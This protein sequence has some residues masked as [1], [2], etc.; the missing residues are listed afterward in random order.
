M[1]LV[2][3]H[4]PCSVFDFN[5]PYC[6]GIELVLIRIIECY[7]QHWLDFIDREMCLVAVFIIGF[8]P[9]CSLPFC[10]LCSSSCKKSTASQ[11]WVR[12]VRTRWKLP[13]GLSSSPLSP[14]AIWSNQE[15]KNEEWSAW[16]QQLLCTIGI[17]VTRM[18]IIN[19]G[20]LH[21]YILQHYVSPVLIEKAQDS[22]QKLFQASYHPN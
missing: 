11:I 17:I 15:R 16:S 19:A 21:L 2:S 10:N 4:E 14:K 3:F 9:L 20:K 12:D 5:N 18:K 7:R 22:I 6:N 8:T 1:N 13:R